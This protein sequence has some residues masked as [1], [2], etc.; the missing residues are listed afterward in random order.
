M[1]DNLESLL[2]ASTIP[3]IYLIYQFPAVMAAW[4]LAYRADPRNRLEQ[5]TVASFI[6]SL[7]M[8]AVP[9]V[10]GLCGLLS[11]GS[12]L[13]G[14]YVCGGVVFLLERSRPRPKLPA[15]NLSSPEMVLL[16]AGIG[17]VGYLQYC[18]LKYL[19]TDS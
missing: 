17:M 3:V 12:I 11:S 5:L 16:S 13:A 2:T 18:S 4:L 9:G 10:L 14:S 19:N 8:I 7:E 1:L 6:F 15:I